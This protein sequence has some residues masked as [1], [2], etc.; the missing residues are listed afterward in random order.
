MTYTHKLAF[1]TIDPTNL[2]FIEL[3]TLDNFFKRNKLRGITLED[4]AAV[5]RR[6]DLDNDSKLRFEEFE[7]G[8]KS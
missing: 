3:K 5:I 1:K 6:F 4:N 7:K 8:I 2:G